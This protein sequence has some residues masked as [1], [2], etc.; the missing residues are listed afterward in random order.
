MVPEILSVVRRVRKLSLKPC[1][2]IELITKYVV[3][4]YI[5]HLSVS[6]PSDAVLMLL[7]SEVRQEMKA[8]RILCLQLPLVYFMLLRTAEGW[9]YQDLNT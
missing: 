3:P 4:Q 6:P 1:Q 5:Y 7:D 8:F 9:G 2:K